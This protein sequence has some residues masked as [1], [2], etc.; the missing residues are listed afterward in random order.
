MKKFI[1]SALVLTLVAGAVVFA[2]GYSTNKKADCCYEGSACCYK[3]SPCCT[4]DHK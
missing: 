2:N 3:G 1:L 4:D